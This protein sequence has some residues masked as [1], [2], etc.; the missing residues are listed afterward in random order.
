[1]ASAPVGLLS[2]LHNILKMSISTFAKDIG[3]GQWGWPGGGAD[4]PHTY[5]IPTPRGSTSA[6]AR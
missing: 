1:M 2:D 3:S 5:I 4:L 6:R